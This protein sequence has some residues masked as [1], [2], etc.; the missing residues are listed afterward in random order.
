[1]GFVL[2]NDAYLLGSMVHNLANYVYSARRNPYTLVTKVSFK[3][4]CPANSLEYWLLKQK[5]SG[6]PSAK[7]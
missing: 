5:A 7:S 4:A 2:E 1:L 3:L 6:N